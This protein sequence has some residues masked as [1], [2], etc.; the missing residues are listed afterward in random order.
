LPDAPIIIENTIFN[1]R[2]EER[3]G[4]KDEKE[5]NKIK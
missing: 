1:S 4:P 2:K 3:Q 5:H